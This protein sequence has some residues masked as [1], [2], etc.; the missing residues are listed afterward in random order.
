MLRLAL[1]LSL[2]FVSSS[3]LAQGDEAVPAS[4]VCPTV[5]VTDH[6]YGRPAHDVAVPATKLDRLRI[7][8][9]WSS[10]FPWASL[11]AVEVWFDG[12][13][14]ANLGYGDTFTYDA[15][16]AFHDRFDR[17]TR[18]DS[19]KRDLL[20]M[21]ALRWETELARAAVL[22]VPLTV[23][24]HSVRPQDP[25]GLFVSDASSR[26]MIPAQDV[27]KV[28]FTQVTRVEEECRPQ[29]RMYYNRLLI[30]VHELQGEHHTDVIHGFRT[31]TRYAVDKNLALTLQISGPRAFTVAPNR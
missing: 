23:K 29:V 1:F 18:Q 21:A 26:L 30:A 11:T 20:R 22:Q 6:L 5:L 15:T 19:Q 12:K 7:V 14:L 13:R 8:R 28:T 2:S 16:P 25:D 31:E 24:L 3:A 4:A 17:Y 27:S 9:R 10:S